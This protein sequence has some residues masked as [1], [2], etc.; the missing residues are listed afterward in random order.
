M[1]I[2]RT[3]YTV[4]AASDED[5]FVFREAVKWTSE[6][7]FSGRSWMVTLLRNGQVWASCVD[8]DDLVGELIYG[9]PNRATA[10]RIARKITA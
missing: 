3:T 9:V 5:G 2:Y 7:W 4:R 6:M 1:T 8:P 10:L